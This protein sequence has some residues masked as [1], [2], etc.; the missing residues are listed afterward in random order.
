VTPAAPAIDAKEADR[1]FA[2]LLGAGALVI[3]VSGGPDSMALMHLLSAWAQR[4]GAA[5][6]K[7]SAATVDHRLRAG[8]DGEAA[9]VAQAA[10]RLGLAHTLL[11]WTAPKPASGIPEAARRARYDLLCAH[12]QAHVQTLGSGNGGDVYIVTAHTQDDQAETFL[13]RL[14]RGAGLDGLSAMAPL[15]DCGVQGVKIARPLLEIAKARLVATLHNLGVAW[16]EDPTNDDTGYERPRV[17][18]ALQRLA[19]ADVERAALARSAGRLGAA[20]EA[21]DYALAQFMAALAL[22]AHPGLFARL[23]RRAF[24]AGPRLLRERVLERLIARFGGTTAKPRLSEVE[25]LV[26]RLDAAPKMTAT[27]GGAVVSAGPRTLRVWREAGRIVPPHRPITPGSVLTWDARFEVRLS[28]AAPGE[29]LTIAPVGAS[30]AALLVPG[31]AAAIPA[32]ALAAL[33]GLWSGGRLAAVPRFAS[34]WSLKGDLPL[35][36]DFAAVPLTERSANAKTSAN[37][38][39]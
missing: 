11:A 37:P 21:V 34:D 20:R 38:I 9:Y 3:A 33:P 17:R 19:E 22:E 26:R 25:A 27:L 28:P 5:A 2:P 16:I 4:I 18:R 23:D 12:A 31:P 35:Q 30:G 13:M 29:A 1:L 7:L 15:R 6:P 36:P 8:S 32:G 39:G 14:Q 10:A 24:D